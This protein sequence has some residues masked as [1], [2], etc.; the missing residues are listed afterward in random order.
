MLLHHLKDTCQAYHIAGI[1]LV[2]KK[3]LEKMPVPRLDQTVDQPDD[4]DKFSHLSGSLKICY[5]K[6]TDRTHLTKR[7]CVV[8]WNPIVVTR[9]F[10]L[11]THSRSRSFNLIFNLA[12][13]LS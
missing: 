13:A 2:S 8:T 1:V 4:V 5:L 9:V 11:W 10:A 6:F 7:R 12:L 3:F